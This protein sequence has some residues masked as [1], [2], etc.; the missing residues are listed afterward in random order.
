MA[1]RRTVQ[2]PPAPRPGIRGG[3]TPAQVTQV[4]K[5]KPAKV[6]TTTGQRRA[7]TPAVLHQAGQQ[8]GQ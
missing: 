1:P 4:L 3:L 6:L 7:L 2:K 8:G 5:S